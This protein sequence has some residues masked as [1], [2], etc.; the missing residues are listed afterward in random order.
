M[1][2]IVNSTVLSIV[3]RT[4]DVF[5]SW[6]SNGCCKLSNQPREYHLITTQ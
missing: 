4:R 6:F 1:R 5:S 2:L 3:I